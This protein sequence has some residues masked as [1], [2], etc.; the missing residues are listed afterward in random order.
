MLGGTTTRP[1]TRPR[2][3]PCTS[4]SPPAR[5]SR[6]VCTST[7]AAPGSR[8]ES[9]STS[10]PRTTTAMR[11]RPRSRRAGTR[12]SRVR[13]PPEPAALRERGRPQGRCGRRPL[14]ASRP[15]HRVPAQEQ[16]G[17]GQVPGLPAD[18]RPRA[19]EF[20]RG[21]RARRE[22]DLRIRSR[23]PRGQV[24]RVLQE[25]V[26]GREAL[27]AALP[28]LAAPLPGVHAELAD[29]LASARGSAALVA[30]TCHEI[31]SFAVPS[32]IE[33]ESCTWR[34]APGQARTPSDL[35]GEL[36]EL[37]RVSAR[38]PPRILRARSRSR[39]SSPECRARAPG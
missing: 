38:S 21:D 6:T 17:Q 26:E 30:C 14:Q 15:A 28:E 13:P 32:M 7:E 35:I 34:R 19:E 36:L 11:S 3:I 4:T 33:G 25:T 1:G 39:A 16:V 37:E 18:G 8:K 9:P 23:G 10:R 31:Y 2:T 12:R 5:S 22:V 20:A 24:A 29:Q 27:A